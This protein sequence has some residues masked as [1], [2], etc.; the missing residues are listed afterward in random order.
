MS[1]GR[2]ALSICEILLDKY[3]NYLNFGEGGVSANLV[4]DTRLYNA[5]V[6]GLLEA[7]K[8]E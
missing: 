5:I 7:K 3:P 2:T 8:D 4:T 1:I 6:E